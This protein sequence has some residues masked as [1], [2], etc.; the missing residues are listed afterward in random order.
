MFCYL[1]LLWKHI[2]VSIPRTLFVQQPKL[3]NEVPHPSSTTEQ[4]NG[5]KP[6]VKHICVCG[7]QPPPAA[8]DPPA[9]T[10]NPRAAGECMGGRGTQIC[11]TSGC[12]QPKISVNNYIYIHIYIYIYTFISLSICMC[13]C[14][15]I[16]IYIY[17]ICVC[18]CI[19]TCMD[20][21]M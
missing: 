7:S 18:L 5:D 9:Q 10:A 11:V 4:N 8:P 1:L 3:E 17:S 16:Y 2:F 19:Y 14:I 15:H 12:W 20:V 21:Y 13:M 6:F